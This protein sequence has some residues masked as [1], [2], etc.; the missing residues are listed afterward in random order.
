MMKQRVTKP[1]RSALFVPG[2]KPSWVEK[3]V[4]SGVDLL[5]I[6]LEDSV[7]VA[8]KASARFLVKEALIALNE[9]GQDCSVRING[10]AT[11]MT[12]DDL[13]SIMCPELKAVSLPKVETVEDMEQLD[14][15][16]TRL[17]ESRPSVPDT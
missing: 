10:L 6:D 17:E 12:L 3:A 8:D 1:C 16:L 13:Q 9:Q 11:G 2:N 14:A 4:A 15:L 7:P 5:I